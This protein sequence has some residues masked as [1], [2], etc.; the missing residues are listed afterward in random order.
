MARHKNKEIRAAVKDATDAGWRLH[1]AT[2]KG[3]VWA[4]L[5]CPG[6]SRDACK[7]TVHGTPKV[8][9]NEARRIRKALRRCTHTNP[10]LR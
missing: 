3:H 4:I 9:E 2:G 5:L 7:V 10:T 1:K 6:A 8:P